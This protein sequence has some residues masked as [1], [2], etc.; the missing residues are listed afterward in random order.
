MSWSVQFIGKPE[1]VATALEAE[2]AK[3]SDQSKVE[4]DAALPHFVALVK[5]NFGNTGTIGTI[6]KF[7]AS[8]H[9][10]SVNGEQK[11]RQCLVNIEAIYGTLV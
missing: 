5:E 11:N 6:L 7:T 3:F 8:G 9:G 10:Y 2:S 4:Y 1:N